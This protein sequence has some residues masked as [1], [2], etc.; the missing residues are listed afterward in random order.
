M[1]SKHEIS[2][3]SFKIKLNQKSTMIKQ[4]KRIRKKKTN[5]IDK[6]YIVLMRTKNHLQSEI[7]SMT[8]Y[9]NKKFRKASQIRKIKEK[10]SSRTV[11]RCVRNINRLTST[12]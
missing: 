7:S 2:T 1:M 12:N 4:E 6:S 3:E 8:T 9:I 10:I 5:E 11:I